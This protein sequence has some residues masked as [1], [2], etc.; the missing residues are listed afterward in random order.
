MEIVGKG[1]WCRYVLD[2]CDHSRRVE[3]PWVSST[4]SLLFI[5]ALSSL[6]SKLLGLNAKILSDSYN[7]WGP[8]AHNC[9]R[10]AEKPEAICAHEQ[11]VFDAAFELTKDT[12]RFTNRKSLLAMHQIFVV[13]PSPKSRQMAIVEFATNRLR[14]IFAR[15]YAQQDQAVRRSFYRTI[16]GHSWFASPAGYMFKIHV[17]LWFWHLGIYSNLF[18]CTGVKGSPRTFTIPSCYGNL[19]F[20]FKAEELKNISEPGKPMC[21]VPTSRTFPTP[22]AIVLTDNAVIAVQI[23]IAF[24]HDAKEQEFDLIYRHLPPDLL[25]KRPNRYHLFI[26]DK[27]INA[28]SLREQNHT[29]IPNGTLVYSTAI[30]VES[31]DS[32]VTEENM[33]ALEKARVSMNWLYAIWC[34][35]GI[36]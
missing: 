33:D 11:D 24:K 36:M 26:T 27:E 23:T 32:M 16:R 9:L 13:R 18:Q 25:A 15:V 35:L 22:D 14:E 6:Y 19:K 10:F 17:L 34:L 3:C 12:S 30:S 7:S 1:V 31:M 28:K 2:G 8:S 21:L 5:F 4:F 20:F 29:Q